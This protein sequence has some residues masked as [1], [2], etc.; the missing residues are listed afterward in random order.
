MM[1]SKVH[2]PKKLRKKRACL[3]LAVV[4]SVEL[5][6]LAANSLTLFL[7]PSTS[8]AESVLMGDGP[9]VALTGARVSTGTSVVSSMFFNDFLFTF[10]FFVDFIELDFELSDNNCAFISAILEA[11]SKSSTLL[12]LIG[13]ESMLLPLTLSVLSSV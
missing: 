1:L 10:G 11:I 7:M 12:I 13:L 9:S 5:R 8:S 2:P 6:N 3:V 4:V